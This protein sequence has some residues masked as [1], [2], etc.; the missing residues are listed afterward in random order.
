MIV[1]VCTH[2]NLGVVCVICLSDYSLVVGMFIMVQKLAIQVSGPKAFRS[3]CKRVK[4]AAA[5][6]E[7][8]CI[9]L[10]GAVYL[11]HI[12]N[13]QNYHNNCED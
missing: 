7:E 6:L 12:Q 1:S 9:A 13:L 3:L 5:H 4:S 10:R 11:P 2:F 8:I